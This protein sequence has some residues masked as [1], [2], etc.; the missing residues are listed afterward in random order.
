M[1]GNK[2][3]KESNLQSLDTPADYPI[4]AYHYNDVIMS[5]MASQVTSLTIV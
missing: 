2:R 5:T 4:G 3:H 1:H